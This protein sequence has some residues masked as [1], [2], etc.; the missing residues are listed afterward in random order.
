LRAPKPGVN[1]KSSGIPLTMRPPGVETPRHPLE[2]ERL[3][4]AAVVHQREEEYRLLFDRNPNPMWVFDEKTL[5]FLAVNDAGLRLY[6]YTRA[7]FLRLSLRDIRPRED[8]PRLLDALGTQRQSR[9]AHAGTWRHCKKDG[10]LFDAEVT[11]SSLRFQAQAARLAMVN[12]ITEQRHSEMLLRQSEERLRLALQGGK[13][14]LWEWDL[15]TDRLIWVEQSVEIS[16]FRKD[17]RLVDAEVFFQHVFPSDL[18]ALRRAL[19]RAVRSGRDFNHEFRVRQE[20]GNL[21]W[22]A[23]RGRAFH[24]E[25]GS[26]RKLTGVTYDITGRKEGES[27]LKALARTLEQRVAERTSTLESVNR[28]LRGQIRRRRQLEA[29]ILTVRE[30]EQ[31]RLGQDLHDGLC[32]MTTATAMMSE[33]LHRDLVEKGFAPE[34]RMAGRIAQLMHSVG[35][36][37]RRLARGLSPVA[38]ES[39]GLMVALEDLALSTSNLFLVRCRFVC[40]VPVLV[41]NNTLAIH[42]F[43]IA[44]EAVNNAI[45][46]GRARHVDIRLER[47]PSGLLLTVKDDGVGLPSRKSSSHGMGLK[48]MRYRADMIGAVI[49][50]QRGGKRGTVF[51]CRVRRQVEHRPAAPAPAEALLARRLPIRKSKRDAAASS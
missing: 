28:T 5:K 18:P 39:N 13:M 29:E 10:T 42:V 9:A 17:H 32:Q 33:G 49:R 44:Q 6:G 45:R 24:S 51:T 37:V 27:Q 38:I 36:E 15:A 12:D 50:L 16:G 20:K 23:V 31:R 48:V 3:R 43:R 34:A 14:D 1:G 25:D 8:V 30:R 46:H 7:E 40:P 22:L 11:V 41:A 21:R 2:D 4:L 35:Q 47:G 19:R 26:S